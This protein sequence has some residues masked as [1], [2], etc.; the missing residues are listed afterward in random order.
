MATLLNTFRTVTSVRG[1]TR[2][3]S[4]WIGVDIG[5]CAVKLAQVEQRGDSWRMT[6]RWVIEHMTADPISPNALA[7]GELANQIDAL[8]QARRMFRG[9]RTAATLPTSYVDLRALDL[10]T[11]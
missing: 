5:A 1:S 8:K 9:R 10:P 3:T 2:P 7:D 4:G 6:A 11:G